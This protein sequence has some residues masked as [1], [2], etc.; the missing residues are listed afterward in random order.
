MS[1]NKSIGSGFEIL[2]IVLNSVYV[3]DSCLLLF[4][5]LIL[6]TWVQQTSSLNLSMKPYHFLL[7]SQKAGMLKAHTQSQLQFSTE[8]QHTVMLNLQ[9]VSEET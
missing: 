7:N 9:K 3:C 1:K 4:S 5:M 6:Q 8:K 2:N